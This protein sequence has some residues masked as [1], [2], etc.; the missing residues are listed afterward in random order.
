MS[1][2][3]QSLCVNANERLRVVEVELANVWTTE[4]EQDDHREAHQGRGESRGEDTLG[5]DN[6]RILRLFRD[7]ARGFESYEQTC[8][9]VVRL[10][11][12]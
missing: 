8:S 11:K 5:G 3:A 4:Q 10:P 9:Y 12:S 6:I 7:V 1:S 2:F